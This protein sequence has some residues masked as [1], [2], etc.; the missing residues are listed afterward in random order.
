[1]P[2]LTVPTGPLRLAGPSDKE[3]A[4]RWPRRGDLAHIALAG[5]C[6]VTHYAVPI[7]HRL[8]AAALL[9]RTTDGETAARLAPGALFDVLDIASGWAWGQ[10]VEATGEHGLVGY[11]P[12]AALEAV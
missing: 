6:F 2:D 1:M 10:V 4:A 12:Q 11:V 9:Q 5:R 8:I 7:R 3:A